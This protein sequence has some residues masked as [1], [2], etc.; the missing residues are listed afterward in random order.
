MPRDL[1]PL[2]LS[3]EDLDKLAIISEADLIK[4]FNQ[5]MKRL[6]GLR[7]ILLSRPL[8]IEDTAVFDGT[9]GADDNEEV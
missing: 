1:V 3:D 7:N 6:G 5:T 2:D 8:D 9:I 4:A